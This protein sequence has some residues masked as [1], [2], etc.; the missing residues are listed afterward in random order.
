MAGLNSDLALPDRSDPWE[1]RVDPAP[2]NGDQYGHSRVESTASDTAM[3]DNPFNDPTREA[4]P[5]GHLGGPTHTQYGEYRDP[6][7]N[8]VQG[9][10]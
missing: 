2:G 4:A 5:A 6:Y 1:A 8:G 9:Q 10:H 7:Y 3:F